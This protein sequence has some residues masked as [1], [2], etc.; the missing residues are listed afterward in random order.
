VRIGGAPGRDH[1]DH[2][3]RS[4]MVRQ[5]NIPHAA[6]PEVIV[7][8]ILSIGNLANHLRASRHDR[9]DPLVRLQLPLPGSHTSLCLPHQPEGSLMHNDVIIKLNELFFIRRGGGDRAWTSTHSRR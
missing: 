3:I 5:V 2:A 4:E 9:V 1:R 6:C 8:P 7:D